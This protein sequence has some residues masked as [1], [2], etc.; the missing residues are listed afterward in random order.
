MAARS[1]GVQ[2]SGDVGPAAVEPQ[3]GVGPAPVAHGQQRA[4]VRLVDEG[5]QDGAGPAAAARRAGT[6][7]GRRAPRCRGAW[8]RCRARRG[9][10]CACRRRRPRTGRARAARSRVR[11][12]VEFGTDTV[13]SDRQRDERGAE[14][15][16]AARAPH[17][18]DEDRLEPVLRAGQR[19]HRADVEDLAVR[20]VAARAAARAR[21]RDQG[22]RR[23][24][25]GH[26][27]DPVGAHRGGDAPGAEDLHGAHVDPGG[28]GEAGRA[29]PPVDDEHAGAVA[30]RG[31]GGGQAAGAGADD[32][33]RRRH[34]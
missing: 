23:G 5:E 13:G 12:R 7:P 16:L 26:D 20:R 14:P 6:A 32:A 1:V 17:G 10:C 3:A 2:S 18:V 4:G 28:A 27:A 34:E 21:G 31:Q 29:G 15:D 24:G 30:G 9:R 11:A 25:L 19:Q 22:G 33:G 8:W